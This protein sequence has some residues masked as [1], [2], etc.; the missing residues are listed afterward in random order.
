MRLTA[1]DAFS[2]AAAVG[3]MEFQVRALCELFRVLTHEDV[4]FSSVFFVEEESSVCMRSV[5]VEQVALS[6]VRVALDYEKVTGERPAE[7][8]FI[9]CALNI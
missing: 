2:N 7:F 4:F 6:R 9:I 5:S 1:R 3:V 8:D